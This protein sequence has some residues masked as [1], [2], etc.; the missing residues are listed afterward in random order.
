MY[1][2]WVARSGASALLSGVHAGGST[3]RKRHGVLGLPPSRTE[4]STGYKDISQEVT[5]L[6]SHK[7]GLDQVQKSEV[8]IICQKED[9]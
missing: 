1:A 5:D 9:F 8:R 6:I 4:E 3:M 7:L 2:L